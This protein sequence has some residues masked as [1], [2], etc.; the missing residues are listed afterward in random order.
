MIR[1]FND[2]LKT[3]FDDNKNEIT[4]VDHDID[5]LQSKQL[6]R[7]LKENTSLT[8]I[9]LIS[10]KIGD[11]GVKELAEALKK[12]TSLT[13]IFIVGNNITDDG[14]KSLAEA[15][16]KNTSIQSIS[17]FANN[18]TNDGVKALAEALKENTSIIHMPLE[19]NKNII[20]T[21]EITKY[22]QRNRAMHAVNIDRSKDPDKVEI[23][24][25]FALNKSKSSCN[26]IDEL[27]KIFITS[28]GLD[29]FKDLP[30]KNIA[31][32]PSKLFPNE[33]EAKSFA[34]KVI[35]ILNNSKIN[36][37]SGFEITETT[38][39]VQ[40]AM[41]NCLKPK[42]SILGA[43]SEFLLGKGEVRSATS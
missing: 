15:L 30:E 23:T 9:T 10:N 38:Q 27:P 37:P 36:L 4:F 28:M 13:S 21:K 18:I 7:E 5:L 20:D 11:D 32:I 33:E 22:I 8:S 14:V 6:S 26:N 34:N 3:L 39:T 1:N 17:L 16:K 25:L 42:T 35:E 12:N 41:N 2:L 40:K 19:P 43:I 31:N 24:L 29:S